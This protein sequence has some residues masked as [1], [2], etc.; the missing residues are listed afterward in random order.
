VANVSKRKV[1]KEF[2]FGNTL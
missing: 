1:I 2:F